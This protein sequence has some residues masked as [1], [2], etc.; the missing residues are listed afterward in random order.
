MRT[1]H[2]EWWFLQISTDF[3]RVEPPT[4]IDWT[5]IWACAHQVFRNSFHHSKL[6]V[7]NPLKTKTNILARDPNQ[8]GWSSPEDKDKT[9]SKPY[10]NQAIASG[11]KRCRPIPIC[12]DTLWRWMCRAQ[13]PAIS[14]FSPMNLFSINFPPVQL[15]LRDCM[16]WHKWHSSGDALEEKYVQWI[17]EL[18]DW[19]SLDILQWDF[20]KVGTVGTYSS[21]AKCDPLIC[22][23]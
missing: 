1:N 15:Q 6:P 17:Y 10:A 20:L 11:P 16:T 3:S 19:P 21:V 7:W 12:G 18:V 4:S 13:K 23:A 22:P 5:Q 9:I 2:L 8:L 14:R